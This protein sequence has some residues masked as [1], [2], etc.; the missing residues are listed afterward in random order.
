MKIAVVYFAVNKKDKMLGIARN[1][2]QGLEYQGHSVDIIDGERESHT[3]LSIYQY[4]AVGSVSIGMLGGKVPPQVSHFL[5]NAGMIGGKRCFAFT[6]KQGLRPQKTL[7]TLM[8]AMEK[9]GLY[10]KFS[11]I[12]S[13]QDEALSVG[14]RLHVAV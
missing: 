5:A 13:D 7:R 1:L 8:A 3:K 4:I 2:A 12:F 14:K 9:E 10:L 11:E 6:M